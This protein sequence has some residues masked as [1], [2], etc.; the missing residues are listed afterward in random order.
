MWKMS[1]YMFIAALLSLALATFAYMLYSVAR[2]RVKARVL[3]LAAEGAGE[4]Q[5]VDA[6]GGGWLRTP[7]YYGTM[8]AWIS[9]VFLT[10][11]LVFR[12]VVTGHGPFQNM[13][14]FSAAFAWGALGAYLWFER[15]YKSRGLAI[16]VVP[17]ALAMLV[18]AALLPS[19]A[20][21]LVPALQNSLLLTVH[22]AVAI[23]AYGVFS[24]G[25]GAAVLYL[26]KK[27]SAFEWIPSLDILDDIG[28]KSVIIAFPFMALVLILG[29]LWANVAWGRYW[30]WDPKETATL[31]TWLI[32]GGYLHARAIR[33]WRGTKSAVL[34][35]IGFAAVLFTYFGNYFFSGLHSYG[36]VGG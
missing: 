33:G 13:Y 10:L 5:A 8:L 15:R 32:Y 27:Y 14:E 29:A 11:S 21:P 34:L 20:Q 22:V 23:V 1:Q 25:F 2:F 16:V 3:A 4:L 31:V 9:L 30:S 18:Y 28:Y 12:G 7:A 19:D 6:A 36:N 17:V 35:L 24:V 26:L